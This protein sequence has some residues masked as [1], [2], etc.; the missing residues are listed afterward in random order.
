MFILT[1][2]WFG[3]GKMK[4]F[5]ILVLPT[6]KKNHINKHFNIKTLF[7]ANIGSSCIVCSFF[8]L[9]F[10][11]KKKKDRNKYI[12]LTF[13]VEPKDPGGLT[14][15]STFQNNQNRDKKRGKVLSELEE[16]RLMNRIVDPLQRYGEETFTPHH[17]YVQYV[18]NPTLTTIDVGA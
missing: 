18:R 8:V 14:N 13:I 6:I 5:Y 2:K 12:Q 17:H 15:R 4:M 3:E 16:T 9:H 7:I 10:Q 1:D 11:C